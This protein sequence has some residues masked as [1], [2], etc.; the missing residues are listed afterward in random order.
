MFDELFVKASAIARHG[1][2]PLAEERR[3]FL[4]HQKQR[5]IPR[6]TLRWH[7]EMLLKVVD[8]LDLQNRPGEIISREEIK[9][10]ATDKKHKF[11]S[12]ATRWLKLLGRL[13]EPDL[14]SERHFEQVEAFANF[15]RDELELAPGTVSLKCAFARNFLK[16][17]DVPLSSGRQFKLKQ[18]EKAFARVL[19]QKNY[20][21]RTIQNMVS[22]LRILLRYAERQNWC[23][24]GLSKA[25]RSPRAF[26]QQSLPSGPS[27]KDV[28]RLLAMTEGD[29]EIE[30]RDR[31][32]LMLFAIYGLRRGEVGHLLLSDIDWER[33]LLTVRCSKSGRPRL[34]PMIKSVGDAILRY[35]KEV[36]PK[37]SHQ[38][39]FLTLVHPIRPLHGSVQHAVRRRIRSLG[40]PLAHYGPHS[41]RHACAT[42]LLSEGMTLKTIGDQ[43]GHTN[44]ETTKIY[45]K[46][47]LVGLRQ[48]ADFD[49]GGLL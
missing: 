6:V 3:K 29:H 10:K 9:R 24:N 5:G 2:R 43:L 38:E 16:Q 36:R 47:D 27:W 44:S 17:L 4:A 7:A 26:S 11:T 23:P 33:E 28:Q 39:I 13:E 48:V 34:Y 20:K 1:G 18:V 32:I 46:V 21:P 8:T 42:R 25:I 49:L 45:A 15:L 40:V 14:S 12:V 41:L 22:H 30:I 37:S 31:P 19:D 35:L